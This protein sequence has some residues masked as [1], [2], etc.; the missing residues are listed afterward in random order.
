MTPESLA[1]VALVLTVIGGVGGAIVSRGYAR[2]AVICN[3]LAVVIYALL[4]LR[5]VDSTPTGLLLMA[6]AMVLTAVGLYAAFRMVREQR[7]AR[8]H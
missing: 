7:R 8:A 6:C 4:L 5:G 2:V 3:G 1:R